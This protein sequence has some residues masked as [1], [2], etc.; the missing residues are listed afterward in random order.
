[1]FQIFVGAINNHDA[2]EKVHLKIDKSILG[3]TTTSVQNILR[4]LI[5]HNPNGVCTDN[6]YPEVLAKFGTWEID[7]SKYLVPKHFE[8]FRNFWF[9]LLG[10]T[11]K[12][13]FEGNGFRDASMNRGVRNRNLFVKIF[14]ERLSDVFFSK[15]EWATLYVFDILISY[16]YMAKS[17]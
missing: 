5:T 6:Q 8:N 7:L 10:T 4:G 16:K 17:K 12:C 1:M 2:H 11:C 15:L 9:K 3:V 14:T 13:I